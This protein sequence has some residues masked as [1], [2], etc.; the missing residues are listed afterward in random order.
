M[1]KAQGGNNIQDIKMRICKW[2]KF[3][4]KSDKTFNTIIRGEKI[5]NIIGYY[6]IYHR[7]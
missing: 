1:G 5:K 7:G 2:I 3:G 4:D 6:P